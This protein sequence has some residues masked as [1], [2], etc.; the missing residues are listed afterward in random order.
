MKYQMNKG[1]ISYG[2]SLVFEDVQFEVRNNEK[3]AIVGRNGCGK[4]TLLKVMMS[5]LRLDRGEIHKISGLTIGYLAQN[6]FKNQEISVKEDCME[7]FDKLFE[8]EKMMNQ[9]TEKMADDY[10]DEVLNRYATLQQQ[11]EDLGG[12]TWQ[13]EM[14]TVFSKFGFN[15]EE[16]DRPISTFSGGQKTRLAFAKLLLSKPDILLLDEPTNHL[17]LQTVTWLEGYIK[18]Y[19]KAVVMVSHDRAF[20]DAIADVVYEIEYHRATRYVGNYS[21]FVKQKQASQEY[22]ERQYK[23]QQEE[24]VRLNQLIEKFRYKKNKAAFAQSKIKYLDRMEKIDA[25]SRDDNKAFKARFR[26]ERKGGKNVVE[27]HQLQIGYDEVLATIDLKVMQSQRIAVI[28]PNGHGKSTF[29]KTLMQ[30]VNPLGGEILFGHQIDP[31]YFDQQLAQFV[32][33]NTVLEECWNENPKLDHTQVRTI[34]GSFLFSADDVFKTV[35]VLSGGE[36]V[37]LSLAKLMQ[38][39]A[40]FIILDEPTNHLDIVGR[41]ALEEALTD[42]EGTL[43]FVSHDRYFIEKMSNAILEIKDGKA[44]Y[45]PF[46]WQ[47]YLLA[48][49][50][51]EISTS[52][53]KQQEVKEKVVQR[54]RPSPSDVKKIEAKIELQEVKLEELRELRFEPEYYQDF[55][56]MN[57]LDQHIDEEVN[58]LEQLH[59]KWEELMEEI[60]G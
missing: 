21:N 47:D 22:I 5:E 19:P 15:E 10:S 45:Y 2:A 49:Q 50:G 35:D 27:V 55:N 17:D 3:I 16:L 14:L 31:A 53:K 6:V 38:K 48:Q 58:N 34:L 40:N 44:I 8:I 60:D 26:C 59:A 24:I 7:V 33:S 25:P 9:L 41:E 23:N 30:Q 54:R 1:T 43:L 57:E 32:R 4:T 28:G 52:F 39:N 13:S 29:V 56:K 20:I 51:V 36:K 11:F 37:R 42:Y 12:Y 46:G 18:R